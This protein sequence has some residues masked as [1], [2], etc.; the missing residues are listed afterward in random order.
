[1][2]KCGRGRDGRDLAGNIKECVWGHMSAGGGSD[3]V[4]QQK[5]YKTEYT[6]LHRVE[7]AKLLSTATSMTTG[8]HEL[9][10]CVRVY[11]HV[12]ADF[13]KCFVDAEDAAEVICAEIRDE[14]VYKY[15]PRTYGGCREKLDE[16]MRLLCASE[17][18]FKETGLLGEFEEMKKKGE[19]Y[20]VCFD[21]YA[22]AWSA[23]L[24]FDKDN[25]NVWWQ[26]WHHGRHAFSQK[27]ST[28]EMLL[29]LQK[30]RELVRG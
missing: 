26:R 15:A 30:M 17:E 11:G 8:L 23:I 25:S 12:K 21:A 22:N 9:M 2:G 28:G 3:G 14:Q 19:H 5:F 24:E 10:V 20:Q 29:L 16:G 13:A 6:C 4:P 27:A 18:K 1:M 7:K